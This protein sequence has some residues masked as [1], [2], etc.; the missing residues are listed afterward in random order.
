MLQELMHEP[1]NFLRKKKKKEKLFN[2][3]FG[4]TNGASV[5]AHDS[6]AEVR[7]KTSIFF[8]VNA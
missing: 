2:N 1:I 5:S 6:T 3:R 7:F 8:N 4:I